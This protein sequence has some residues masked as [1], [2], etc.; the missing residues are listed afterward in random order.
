MNIEKLKD[1]KRV[2]TLLAIDWTPLDQVIF[3]LVSKDIY[4]KI[5]EG[6]YTDLE[7]RTHFEMSYVEYA[8]IWGACWKT[9]ASENMLERIDTLIISGVPP[10][11]DSVTGNIRKTEI[12]NFEFN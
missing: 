2:I 8:Y 10:F 5:I 7:L 6:L 4:V 1:F 3:E 11:W 9:K 12:K